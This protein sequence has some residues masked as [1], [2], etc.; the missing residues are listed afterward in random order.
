MRGAET[1]GGRWREEWR[2]RE[3][4]R[5]RWRLGGW[6]ELQGERCRWRKR[7][8][9]GKRELEIRKVERELEG[10]RASEVGS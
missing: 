9:D 6:C 4:V 5:E 3:T 10:E 2:A 8:R 1:H 7:E